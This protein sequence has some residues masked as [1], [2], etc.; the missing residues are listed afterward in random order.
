MSPVDPGVRRDDRAHRMSD[1]KTMELIASLV[2]PGSRVLDLGCGNGALLAHLR[3]TRQCSGYGIE[4]D[5]ANVL[6]CTQRGVNV[7]QLN[8]EDGLAIF[9]DQSFDVVLQ[10]DTMQHLR[11]TERLLRETARVGRVGVIS[12][13][14]F[15]HW[16]NRL[17]V[18][19]GRMPVTKALP[20]QWYDTPNIRV[21][22][23]TDCEVLLRKDGFQVLDA[24][25]IQEGRAVRRFP[26]LMA[27]VAV[28]KFQRG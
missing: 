2:P 21:G 6:A 15:A 1:L 12:F 19:T 28:F 10:L 17:R 24:F 8:L 11:H 20:Y 18:V 9:E 26:N 23:Y 4:I 22:T 3:D 25:G 5:D 7:I 16:P 14:N 13:P 27:S